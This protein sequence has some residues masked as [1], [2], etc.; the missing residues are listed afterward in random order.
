YTAS[1]IGNFSD[2]ERDGFS[3]L[4]DF[5]Q[6]RLE[7]FKERPRYGD[8]SDYYENPVHWATQGAAA[9]PNCHPS[10]TASQQ[11]V[12]DA[13][14]HGG[15]ALDAV[16]SDVSKAGFFSFRSSLIVASPVGKSGANIKLA[17]AA[18]VDGR[19]VTTSFS[20]P[21]LSPPTTGGSSPPLGPVPP[22]K[23]GNADPSWFAKLMTMFP[24]EAVTAY[25][26]GMH[27][28]GGGSLW[29]VAVTLVAVLIVRWVALTSPEGRPNVVAVVVSGISFLLW[30]GA[31][32]D[33]PL[34][35]QIYELANAT[36][37]MQ[38]FGDT[39]SKGASFAILLWTWILPALVKINPES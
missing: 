3:R 25:L 11:P 28:F 6:D 10:D 30:V 19:G 31:T 23:K 21:P 15:D 36:G 26:T 20:G 7:A 29:L 37:G 4:H 13:A 34:A 22:P 1:Q 5:Y 39:L 9:V 18:I 16:T 27:Y 32:I 12:Y 2:A 8:D 24:A 38:K 17:P 14:N 33:Q 35:R